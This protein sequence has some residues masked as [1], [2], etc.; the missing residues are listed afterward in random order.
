MRTRGLAGERVRLRERDPERLVADDGGLEVVVQHRAAR[1]ADVE[2]TG[3]DGLGHLRL[4]HLAGAHA[5]VGQPLV[6]G[7]DER[8]QRLLGDRRRVGDAQRA[9]LAAAG[10]LRLLDRRGDRR[11]DRPGVQEQRAPGIRQ[12]DAARRPMEERRAQLVLE[13]A[14]LRAERLL[15]QV[16]PSRGAGEVQLLGHGDERAQVTQLEAR[17]HAHMMRDVEDAR[18][19]PTQGYSPPIRRSHHDEG[20]L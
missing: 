12:L 6:D 10:A 20:H 18:V 14:D 13:L 8:R 17:A 11:E 19:A 2:A 15:R 4:P 7:G 3:L 16:Q 9:Q 1:Q 5:H